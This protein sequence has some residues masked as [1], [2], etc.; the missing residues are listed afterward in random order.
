MSAGGVNKILKPILDRWEREY[1]EALVDDLISGQQS[2]Q[3]VT[4]LDRTLDQLQRGQ[5]REVVVTRGLTGSAEQCVHLDG[6]TGLPTQP[7]QSAGPNGNLEACVL[8]VRSLP[9]HSRSRWR[10]WEVEPQVG[11]KQQMESAPGCALRG[12]DRGKKTNIP[13]LSRFGQRC[14]CFLSRQSQRCA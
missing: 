6:S 8:C 2:C 4:G 12:Y 10:W 14:T 9:V 7:A 13:V 1:E 11:Y 3:S 5:A